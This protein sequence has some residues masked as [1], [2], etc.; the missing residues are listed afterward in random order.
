M[1]D[2]ETCIAQNLDTGSTGLHNWLGSAIWEDGSLE[3]AVE[4]MD[5]GDFECLLAAVE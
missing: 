5:D 1:D 2:T 3:A 4:A